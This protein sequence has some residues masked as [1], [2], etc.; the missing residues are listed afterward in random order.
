MLKSEHIKKHNIFEENFAR[1]YRPRCNSHFGLGFVITK[2]PLYMRLRL[3]PKK[4]FFGV[5]I[6]SAFGR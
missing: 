3:S 2:P 4:L 5:P 1:E 6:K